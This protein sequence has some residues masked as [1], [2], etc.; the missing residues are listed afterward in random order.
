MQTDINTNKECSRAKALWSRETSHKIL[1]VR[2]STASN[3][4]SIDWKLVKQKI[5][6]IAA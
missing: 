4:W 1:Q 3:Q 5:D 6:K 2:T